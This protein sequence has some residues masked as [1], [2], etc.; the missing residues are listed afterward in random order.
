[1]KIL[2]LDIET[3][4][5]KAYCWGLFEQNISH[6]QVEE[7]GY[8][9]CW[10]AKWYGKPRIH[11][12]SEQKA[13]RIDVLRP[14]HALLDEAEIVIHFN[15]TKFDIPILNREF[16]KHGLT[17]PSPYR[18]IDLL[19]VVRRAFRFESNKLAY[20]TEALGL[21]GKMHHE[22]FKLWVGCMNGDKKSWRTMGAYNRRD[23]TIMEP[24]YERLRPWIDRHPNIP[25]SHGIGCPKCGSNNVQRRGVQV[26]ISQTYLRLQCQACGGWFRS[27]KTLV[28]DTDERGV[29][30]AS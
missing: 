25:S 30:I 1:V 15:G 21:Q 6:D 3:A 19:R 29:N 22:G 2:F 9:L 11:F 20:V 12:A 13:E 27:S 8:I 4:P 10:S 26:A 14:I 28:R 16:V 7:S 18:Q 23:V 17:P 5:N 24:L